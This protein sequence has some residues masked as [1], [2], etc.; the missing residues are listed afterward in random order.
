MNVHLRVGDN[1]IFSLKQAVLLYQEGSRA[2]ATL[3]EV[4]CRPSEAPYLCAGQSVTTGFLETLAKGLGA[5]MAAEVLPEHV[6]A[7]TPELIAWWSRAQLRLMFFG[8][9]NAEAK[10]LNGKMYPH[11]ALLFI[12]DGRELIVRALAE[13]CRPAA[14]TQ[15]K[16]A[17]YWNT[18]PA[19]RVCLGSMRIPEEVNVGSLSGW[20]NAY[21]A[22][23]F[24]HPSGA[25]RLTTHSGGFLGLW[26]NLA[27]RKH[28]PVKYL[29]DS[30]QTLQEF[31]ERKGEG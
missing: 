14:Y 15:L 19:G 9:G 1:R 29:A 12:I 5:S 11:P 22:S 4:K 8:N 20:E 31:I 18:D 6:L 13:N 7:R 30:K 27:G 23:E 25:V 10:K 3:H 16:N 21:F 2:F 26:S 28:F 17:P 24:T